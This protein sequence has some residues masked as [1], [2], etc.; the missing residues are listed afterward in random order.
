MIHMYCCK[1]FNLP[2]TASI[3]FNTQQY[4]T[5]IDTVS[6]SKC[7]EQIATCKVNESVNVIKKQSKIGFFDFLFPA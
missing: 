5:F 7:L 6:I 1:F 4:C 3:L 2:P